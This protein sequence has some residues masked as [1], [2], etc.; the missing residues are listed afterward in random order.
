MNQEEKQEEEQEQGQGD[1]KVLTFIINFVTIHIIFF[2][3]CNSGIWA[4]F[5]YIS[6]PRPDLLNP[7]EMPVCLE[8]LKRNQ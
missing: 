3:Y 2:V 8:F 4:N 7:I 6:A 5:A 1:S